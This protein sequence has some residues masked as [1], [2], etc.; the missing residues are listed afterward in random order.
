MHVASKEDMKMRDF[1]SPSLYVFLEYSW[2]LIIVA[3]VAYVYELSIVTW[4]RMS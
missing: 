3:S 4:V 2:K 1:L